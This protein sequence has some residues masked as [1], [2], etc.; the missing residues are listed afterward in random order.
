MVPEIQLTKAPATEEIRAISL[1]LRQFNEVAGGR[2]YEDDPLAILVRDPES[3]EVLG[4]LLAWTAYSILHIDLFYLPESLRG[5]GLGTRLLAQAEEEAIRRG[6]HTAWLD[7][8]SF[9]APTLYQR[10]GYSIF[11]VIEGY[12]PGHSRYFLKKPL[13][14]RT[15]TPQQA[16]SAQRLPRDT[17]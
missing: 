12:A 16:K 11:G 9:Q 10:L 4:G 17:R 15:A 7:T 3:S 14:T 1:L 2:P 13:L 8:F 5:A 6:C